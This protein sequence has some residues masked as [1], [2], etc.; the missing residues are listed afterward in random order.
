MITPLHDPLNMGVLFSPPDSPL[1]EGRTLLPWKGTS[2]SARRK[3]RLFWLICPL[4][5]TVGLIH[6]FYPYSR[7]RTVIL[8]PQSVAPRVEENITSEAVASAEGSLGPDVDGPDHGILS[9]LVDQTFPGGQDPD[10]SRAYAKRPGRG[11]AKKNKDVVPTKDFDEAFR[12]VISLLPSEL[13]VRGLLQPLDG[14]TGAAR[15]RELGVRTRGYKKYLEAWEDLHLVPDSEGGTY[16]RDDVI[17]YIHEQHATASEQDGG[18]D[19]AETIHAYESY[20]S[21]LVQLSELL[22]PFTAPYFPD[23]MTLR[24]H[25]QKGGRGIALTAGNDQVAYLLTQIPI[26]RRLGCT[27]PIEVMY[28][29]DADLNRDSRQDLEDLEGV[30]TRDIGSMVRDKGWTLAGW[31][32]KPFAILLSSFR[33]VICECK[34]SNSAQA[35]GTY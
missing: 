10:G 35:V 26:L 29:S 12:R 30:V 18:N 24:S 31:A 16:I 20:R 9:E 21:L 14:M 17:Q 23:H 5:L 32:I 6:V 3:Q 27:L 7:E 19:L 15:L 28:A 8:P 2:R 34:N 22:F 4:F 25:I 11:Q 13:E 1:K 33:E